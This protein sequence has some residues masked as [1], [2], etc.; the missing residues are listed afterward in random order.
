MGSK[1]PAQP[2]LLVPRVLK[3]ILECAQDLDEKLLDPE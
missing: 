1:S 3:V 2:R